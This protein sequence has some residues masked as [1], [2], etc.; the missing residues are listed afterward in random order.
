MRCGPGRFGRWT[1]EDDHD[2]PP[3]LLAHVDG[4]HPDQGAADIVEIVP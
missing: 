1:F 3:A 4:R 2:V